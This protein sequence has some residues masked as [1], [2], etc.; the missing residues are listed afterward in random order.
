MWIP[1]RENWNWET[2]KQITDRLCLQD[3]SRYIFV[4]DFTGADIRPYFPWSQAPQALKHIVFDINDTEGDCS[5]DMSAAHLYRDSSGDFVQPAYMSLIEMIK[6]PDIPRSVVR[7]HMKK[8]Y[9]CARF[10]LWKLY[11]QHAKQ[12]E[13][14]DWC[15]PAIVD[16]R[17]QPLFRAY[18]FYNASA[19][20]ADAVTQ[21]VYVVTRDLAEAV[22][23]SILVKP[24]PNTPE[25]SADLKRL[26]EVN[27]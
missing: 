27:L 24:D 22:D 9:E 17:I 4:Q 16:W 8:R 19:A 25:Y 2:H 14:R 13:Y 10:W 1:I 15:V 26:I 12:E 20:D 6:N 18:G 23:P 21:L 7:D 5:P 3:K 11:R